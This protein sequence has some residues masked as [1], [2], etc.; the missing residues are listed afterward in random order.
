MFLSPVFTSLYNCF[1][2][3]STY[4]W[5][6]EWVY[7]FLLASCVQQCVYVIDPC[8]YMEWQFIH[9]YCCIV[10]YCMDLSHTTTVCFHF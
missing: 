6:Q 9:L 7:P 5:S 10:F 3:V 2:N 4:E 1:V 8:C